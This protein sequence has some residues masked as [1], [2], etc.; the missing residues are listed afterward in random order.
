M[1]LVGTVIFM[2]VEERVEFIERT[3][4]KTRLEGLE[5]TK[6]NNQLSRVGRNLYRVQGKV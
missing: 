6:G 2:W 1:Y 4:S 3:I 5:Q